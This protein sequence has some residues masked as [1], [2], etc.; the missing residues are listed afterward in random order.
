MEDGKSGVAGISGLGT[1]VSVALF[2]TGIC[3][4]DRRLYLYE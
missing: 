2:V 4:L 3:I 1:V